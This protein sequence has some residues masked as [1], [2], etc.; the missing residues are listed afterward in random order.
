MKWQI[1]AVFLLSLTCWTEPSNI[2]SRLRM[3]Q[4]E[5]VSLS[6][7]ATEEA[8]ADAALQATLE[9]RLSELEA[10]ANEVAQA[11][12]ERQVRLNEL[13]TENQNQ[14]ARL[15]TSISEL[16]KANTQ[17]Q[18][19]IGGGVPF[20]RD[21]RIS[22]FQSA[23]SKLTS[24]ELQHQAAGAATTLTLLRNEIRLAQETSLEN[25][26]VEISVN[27]LETIV[28]AYVLRIGLAQQFFVSEDGR[29]VALAVN[30]AW[31]LVSSP[32]HAH[33]IREA[34]LTLRKRRGASL[35]PIPVCP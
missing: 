29:T 23:H 20:E 1:S 2:F 18:Q 35:T 19:I 5:A 12:Q 8:Q 14:Q 6:Q 31:E 33:A 16:Q 13:A 3:A 26:K 4:D 30:G 32:E 11:L 27:G 22:A 25:T 28:D 9:Q 7:Q 24:E 10:R 21:S 34:I 17:A 15:L